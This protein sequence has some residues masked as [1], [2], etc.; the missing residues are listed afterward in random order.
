MEHNINPLGFWL[1]NDWPS[2]GKVLLLLHFLRMSE[3]AAPCRHFRMRRVL[4]QAREPKQESTGDLD[5]RTRDADCYRSTQASQRNKVVLWF[6]WPRMKWS[7]Q[8]TPA[9]CVHKLN[10]VE[11]HSLARMPRS[12]LNQMLVFRL[13]AFA[14]TVLN[15]HYPALFVAAKPA[16]KYHVFAYMSMLCIVGSK[17]FA[18]MFVFFQSRR[19]WTTNEVVCPPCL[20]RS[21]AFMFSCPWSEISWDCL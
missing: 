17:A 11:V 5:T 9:Y 13:L 12:G 18:C 20:C 6:S 10:C 15:V 1:G 3:P 19:A 21:S 16:T 4:M 2:N 14:A 7:Q 8:P